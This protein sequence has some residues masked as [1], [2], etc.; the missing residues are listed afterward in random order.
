MKKIY[1]NLNENLIGKIIAKDIYNKQDILV[2]TKDTPINTFILKRMQD[3]GIS[4]V[5]I[6]NLYKEKKKGAYQELKKTYNEHIIMIKRVLKDLAIGK[7]IDI[8]KVSKFYDSMNLKSYSSHD[9]IACINELRGTDEYT[10]THSINVSLYALLTARWLKLSDHEIRDIVLAGILHD[11]GKSKI[12][13]EILNKKGKL[14]DREFTEMKKHT[15][16]GYEI[17]RS[18]P[19]IREEICRTILMH[20]ER[21]DGTGYPLGAKGNQIHIYTK[22]ISISDVYDALNSKRVYKEKMIPFNIF[23]KIFKMGYG[24]FDTNVMLTFIYNLVNYYIGIK[25]KMNSG[26]IGEVIYISQD[27]NFNP[28]IKIND[29]IIDLAKHNE[30][31][32]IEI[33]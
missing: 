2:I 14:T 9:I 3:L 7:K 33:I 25:V 5:Y 23:Q 28:I 4:K 30:Y 10:Y 19:E 18:I 12:P 26:E 13:N 16:Y 1:V 22:I 21:E 32:I 15:L 29:K 6:Y 27:D 17:S 20:H 8:H 24:Y 31:K 11:I